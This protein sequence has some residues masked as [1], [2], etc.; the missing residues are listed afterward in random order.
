ML[1]A[2]DRSAVETLEC[3][4]IFS[5]PCTLITQLTWRKD[6]GCI[7]LADVTS[8]PLH[9][10]PANTNSSWIVADNTRSAIWIT[11]TRCNSRRLWW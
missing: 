11:V 4:S 9:P 1:L 5:L 2:I 7:S 10:F 6:P 8:F 3:Y